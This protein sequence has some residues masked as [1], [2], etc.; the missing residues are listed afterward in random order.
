MLEAHADSEEIVSVMRRGNA[1]CLVRRDGRLV[2]IFTRF[3]VVR[4]LTR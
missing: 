3:D 1:A 4:A 2:G